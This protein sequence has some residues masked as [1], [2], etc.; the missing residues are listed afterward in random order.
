MKN[1]VLILGSLLCLPS[2]GL[3][4]DPVWLADFKKA[5]L[6]DSGGLSSVELSKTKSSKLQPI[7][8]NFSA[9]DADQDG[10][11]TRSEY[12]SYLAKQ[13]AKISTTQ[14]NRADL[15]DSGGLSRVE[16]DKTTDK[17]FDP[18]RQ[19]F[20]SIDTDKD[21][22]ASYAEYETFV[23]ASKAA[24][25]T[26]SSSKLSSPKDQCQPN[27]GVV[28]AVDRYKVQGEGSALGAIAGGVAGGLLGN[29]VGGGTG[30]TIATVG[31]AAGGAY[32]GHK[33][34]ER[35]KTKKMVKVKV[36]FDNGEQKD[37]DFEADKSPVAKGERVL[38]EDGKPVKY[39]GQ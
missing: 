38:I 9:I 6:N 32:A 3:A 2:I 15:N 11:V 18:V 20:D 10:Q 37:F 29:Q 16:L 33:I 26:A 36:K 13:Q 31:G 1:T 19:N 17:V 25:A 35:M 7:K 34:E 5:D 27:C 39:T 23:G 28:L 21:G 22:Q 12:E 4:A 24:A 30:K 14:F 8:A